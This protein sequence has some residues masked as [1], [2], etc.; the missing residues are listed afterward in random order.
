MERERDQTKGGGEELRYHPTTSKQ[1]DFSRKVV[2]SVV[3]KVSK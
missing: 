3:K 1:L 2:F